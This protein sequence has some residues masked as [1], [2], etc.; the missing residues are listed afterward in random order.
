[1]AGLA[2][3]TCAAPAAN[4]AAA[5]A[6]GSP[7][8]AGGSPAAPLQQKLIEW[9]ALEIE[10][11][12]MEMDSARLELERARLEEDKTRMQEQVTQLKNDIDALRDKIQTLRPPAAPSEPTGPALFFCVEPAALTKTDGTERPLQS[13]EVVER[14]AD[15]ADGRWT[16][17]CADGVEGTLAASSLESEA[18][19]LG[20]L[21]GRM[22]D[23]RQLRLAG[24][25]QKA[26]LEAGDAGGEKDEKALANELQLVGQQ[27]K[28][29]TLGEQQ[30]A[31]ALERL[32]AMADAFR[33]ARVKA[34]APAP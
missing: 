30:V 32:T 31:V 26:K 29:F 3:A 7:T 15:A 8:A 18:E 6:K 14:L 11:M 22:E 5:A 12:R 19:V 2:C 9:R 20:N 34:P 16:V 17:R 33:A 25:K 27:I 21:R 24:E 13:M 28:K 23:L 1:M 10:R 4:P